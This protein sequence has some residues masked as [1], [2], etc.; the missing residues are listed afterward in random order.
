M[1]GLHSI[2]ADFFLPPPDL[3]QLN[4]FAEISDIRNIQYSII[5]CGYKRITFQSYRL[6][7]LPPPDLCQLNRFAEI[8]DNSYLLHMQY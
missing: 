3:C 2:V 7:L 1:R 6:Y 8:S 5:I 4:R